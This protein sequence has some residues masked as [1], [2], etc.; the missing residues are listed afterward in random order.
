[1]KIWD[2][3][4]SLVQEEREATYG[5]K[6]RSVFLGP[7]SGPGAGVRGF[8][9]RK[10]C[11]NQLCGRLILALPLAENTDLNTTHFWTF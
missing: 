11:E 1:M 2:F 8:L 10:I 6:P 9:P 5:V 3:I 7:R 4:P